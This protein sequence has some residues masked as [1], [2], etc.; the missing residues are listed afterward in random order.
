VKAGIL[1]DYIEKRLEQMICSYYVQ[2]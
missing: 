1:A 2:L